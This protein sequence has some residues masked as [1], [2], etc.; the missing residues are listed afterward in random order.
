MRWPWSS[1]GLNGFFFVPLFAPMKTILLTPDSFIALSRQANELALAP[2][3]VLSVLRQMLSNR[4]PVVTNPLD[5]HIAAPSL[6]EGWRAKASAKVAERGMFTWFFRLFANSDKALG[7]VLGPEFL[8]AMPVGRD[9]CIFWKMWQSGMLAIFEDKISFL[10]PQDDKD[11]A[12]LERVQKKVTNG[13]LSYLINR[14][15]E[16]T[17]LEDEDIGTVP[18]EVVAQ[19]QEYYIHGLSDGL[20]AHFTAESCLDFWLEVATRLNG[21]EHFLVKLLAKLVGEQSI[22]DEQKKLLIDVIN[23][24]AERNTALTVT[25]EKSLYR[26]HSDGTVSLDI[27]AKA[28]ERFL[29]EIPGSL[30]CVPIA[31]RPAAVSILLENFSA[32]KPEKKAATIK[33]LFDYFDDGLSNQLKSQMLDQMV[34]N[35]IAWDPIVAGTTPADPAVK[36][37]VTQ[38]RDLFLTAAYDLSLDARRRHFSYITL[39]RYRLLLRDNEA[40]RGL[41]SLEE[42]RSKPEVLAGLAEVLQRGGPYDKNVGIYLLRDIACHADP[43]VQKRAVELLAQCRLWDRAKL[44]GYPRLPLLADPIN[45][46]LSTLGNIAEGGEGI[47]PEAQ[48][49]AVDALVQR[50]TPELIANDRFRSA[51]RKA[52]QQC[53][54]NKPVTDKRVVIH[55]RLSGVAAAV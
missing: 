39:L 23:L 14:V 6:T 50:A 41:T 25:V 45:W 15:L 9:R 26:I 16:H 42:F 17:A 34:S 53:V 36:L 40:C 2:S 48:E 13:P 1:Y 5:G 22:A 29:R 43:E 30:L 54:E 21:D 4:T 49:M 32:I 38:D 51:A 33:S 55:Q 11:R 24:M 10:P 46:L 7:R 3:S 28:A 31:S 47:S 12:W 19:F 44:G 37:A 27:Q 52:L 8:K 35:V 20:P 18:P